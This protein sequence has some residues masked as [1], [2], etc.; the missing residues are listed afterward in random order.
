M[1]CVAP[2]SHCGSEVDPSLTACS[3]PTR[4][5]SDS[6]W[7]EKWQAMVQHQRLRKEQDAQL[8]Q[9][10]KEKQELEEFIECTFTPKTHCT[11]K[12]R[13]SDELLKLMEPLITEE[14]RIL[15]E[16]A[17]LNA[18]EQENIQ[19]HSR[20]LRAHIAANQG[21]EGDDLIRICERYRE[22]RLKEIA[23]VKNRKLDIVGL[24]H[25]VERK[26]NIICVKEHL[27][28]DDMLRAC[29]SI[30]SCR[31]IKK[32][33]LD[34]VKGV[35]TLKDRS[36]VTSEIDA[37]IKRAKE[38]AQRQRS[39]PPNGPFMPA[40]AMPGYP[41]APQWMQRPSN[42]LPYPTMQQP[43]PNLWYRPAFAKGHPPM[44]PQQQPMMKLNPAWMGMRP[45][46]A[47]PFMRQP[48]TVAQTAKMQTQGAQQPAHIVP[49][50]VFQAPQMRAQPG[51]MP[52]PGF[53]PGNPP[54]G[55]PP[56][57]QHAQPQTLR[58]NVPKKVQQ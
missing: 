12:S 52:H 7:D 30:D 46:Q 4:R 11:Y 41:V 23:R 54:L 56:Q 33:I 25:E 8:H 37:I 26:Y 31:L 16:L 45:Q 22:E 17:K 38:D 29:F 53:V 34:S 1:R 48:Q 5:M 19:L 6:A 36:R 24:L 2:G 49:R 3:T 14:E 28:E 35:D 21:G 55:L 27:N 43:G 58:R 39:R 42:G 32:E 20:A 13:S 44:N 50:P 47:Q 9:K 57:M 10:L 15:R 40:G 51:M 18:E